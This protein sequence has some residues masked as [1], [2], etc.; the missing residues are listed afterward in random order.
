M[1]NTQ[2]KQR[3]LKLYEEYENKMIS[4]NQILDFVRD[5]FYYETV[6]KSYEDWL[7]EKEGN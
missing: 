1:K 7:S 3:L 2:V 4:K 5:F 6:G